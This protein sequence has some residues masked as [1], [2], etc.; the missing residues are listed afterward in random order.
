MDGLLRQWWS[1]WN[2]ICRFPKALDVVDYSILI[3]KISM[4]KIVKVSLKWF[5]SHLN[6]RQQVIDSDQGLFEFMRVKFGASQGP[7]LG[8]TL[9]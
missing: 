8:P 5:I 7:I 3:K 1:G 6:N 4:Y 9:F 2:A